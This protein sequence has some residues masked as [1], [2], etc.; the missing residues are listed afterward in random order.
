MYR[1]VIV[2][3]DPMVAL[4]DRTYVE[5]DPRFR[6]VQTFQDGRAAL[7]W[8]EQNPAELAVLDV[9][10]PLLTGAELLRELRRRGIGIDAVM[11]TAANDGATVDTLLK[12][13][14]VDYLAERPGQALLLRPGGGAADPQGPPGEHPGEGAG[15]PAPG[16]APG[17]AQRGPVPG[18]RPVR[19][20][21]PPVCQ[22][23][24]GAGGGGQHRQLRHRRPALPPLPRRRR[25]G[26]S[27]T[28]RTEQRA[29]GHTGAR[30]GSMEY[31]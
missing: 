23:P 11:V 6:V 15:L 1:V 18:H 27:P 17:P 24:G 26:V 28:G 29:P 10:M 25:G 31:A 4:L 2:E 7:E 20:H 16:A 5:R 19:R 8:L 22:L 13:G 12:M 14:V 9:Y 21:R 30:E 3:D